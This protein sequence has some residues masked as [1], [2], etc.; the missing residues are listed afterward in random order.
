MSR[1]RDP[2]LVIRDQQI[3]QLYTKGKWTLDAL[4]E[5]YSITKSAIRNICTM[6][7]IKEESI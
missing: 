6:E 2:E 3:Y 5:K 7:R 1:R 4:A